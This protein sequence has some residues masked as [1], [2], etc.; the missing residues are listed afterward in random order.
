MGEFWA[1]VYSNWC[2]TSNKEFQE[3]IIQETQE[4]LNSLME[5]A[6]SINISKNGIFDIEEDDDDI[7]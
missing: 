2:K 4:D 5:Q 1:I 6:K 3:N 7:E